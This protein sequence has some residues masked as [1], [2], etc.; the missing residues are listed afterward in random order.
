MVVVKQIDIKNQIYFFTM[1]LLT[2]KIRQR[3]RC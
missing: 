1:T 3:Q 2:S